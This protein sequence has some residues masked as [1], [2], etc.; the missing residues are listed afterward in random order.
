MGFA[1][2]GHA[3]E[4]LTWFCLAAAKTESWIRIVPEDHHG[5]LED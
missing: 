1:R 2:V 5:A 4:E 3:E